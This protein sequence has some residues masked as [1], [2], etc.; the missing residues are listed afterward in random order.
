MPKVSPTSA[1]T[2]TRSLLTETVPDRPA[3]S[4]SAGPAAS[5]TLPKWSTVSTSAT[6]LPGNTATNGSGSRTR[7]STGGPNSSGATPS[8]RCAAAGAKTSRPWNVDDVTGRRYSGDASSY[9]AITPLS[10]SAAGM[11][12]PLSGPTRIPRPA[13]T[14]TPRRAV[15][16]PGSTTARCT[17]SGR[18]GAVCASTSA[19][20]LTC[21][22]GISWLTS[23][24]R[25]EGAIRAI[26]PWQ[27]ATKPSLKP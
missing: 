23:M 9:A 15:P 4:R 22:G 3:S 7:S 12:S 27:A 14:T 20:V 25:A 8:A 13:T 1:F 16:T 17:A 24:I 26:T 19:P 6:S 11:R 5:W 18:K 2:S 21:C 10:V